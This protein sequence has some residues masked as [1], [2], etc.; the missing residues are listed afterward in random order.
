MLLFLIFLMRA[1]SAQKS[2]WSGNPNTL[3]EKASIIFFE[4][5]WNV[6]LL[7]LNIRFKCSGTDPE[8]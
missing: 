2:K 7:L 1:C 3:L 8:V 4:K 6:V 5:V